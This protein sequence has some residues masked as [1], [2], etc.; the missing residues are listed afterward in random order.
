MQRCHHYQKKLKYI[1]ALIFILSNTQVLSSVAIETPNP[2]WKNAYIGGFIGGAFGNYKTNTNTGSL[3]DTSY[4][5]SSANMNAVNQSGSTSTNPNAFIVG[6]KAGDDWIWKNIVFGAILDYGTFRQK[7]T[8]NAI[9][10]TYP[11]NSGSYSFQSSLKTDWLFTLRGRVGVQLNT[12]STSLLYAS[13]GMAITELTVSNNFNDNTLLLGTGSSSISA[14]QIGWTLGAGIDY[15]FNEHVL[16][17]AEY[18]YVSIPSLTT[19][20]TIANSAEGF[21]IPANSFSNPFL[22][23]AHFF[24]NLFRVGVSYRFNDI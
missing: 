1:F 12:S 14:N 19:N 16:F 2:L 20:G 15:L 13:G 3:S 22:T 9:N 18:L 7:S 17:N 10:L 8:I 11:D 6:I 5:T 23:T 21:G 24:S 4:F